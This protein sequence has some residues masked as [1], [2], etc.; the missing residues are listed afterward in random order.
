MKRLNTILI[1]VFSV[2]IGGIACMNLLADDQQFSQAENRPL[3][4]FPKVSLERITSGAFTKDVE[5]YLSDQFVHKRFWTSMKASAQKAALKK[6]NNGV[7]FGQDGYLFEKFEAPSQQLDSNS[8]SI[9]QFLQKTKGITVYGLL[10]PTSIKVY[11]EKLPKFATTASEAAAIQ[12]VKE[13][14][15]EDME[16]IDATAAL[17]NAKAGPIYFRTDHHWTPYGAYIAYQA[18]MEKMGMTPY[19]LDEFTIRTVSENFRGTYDAKANDPFLSA[20]EI[21]IFEPKFDVSYDVDID[22]GQS[23]MDSLYAWEFLEKRDQ[24]SLFLGGNHRAVTIHSN[25]NNGRK[26]M[27]IKDSYAHSLV[28]FLANHF[29]EIYMVDLR[30]D[31]RNMAQIAQDKG[32]QDVL[33]VYNIANF[34]EDQNLIWLRR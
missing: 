34:A 24:Y 5:T 16:W 28:P 23:K 25:V 4:Q 27:I 14:V 31:H 12:R 26:L 1:I 22:D 6:D 7:Y 13:Q 17:Q 19:S 33:F 8:E 30:Y 29:E 15:T 2:F 3:M 20:D 11:P 21:N 18:T 9:S 32:I 10:A